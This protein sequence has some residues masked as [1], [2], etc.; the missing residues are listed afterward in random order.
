MK[1][2]LGRMDLGDF[3]AADY[4]ESKRDDVTALP[5]IAIAFSG[6]GY[7]ALMNGAGA[8]KAFDS[9][10]DGATGGGQL[11]GLFQASTYV[12]GLSGGSWLV[13]SMYVNNFTTISTLQT[14]DSS[15]VWEFSSSILKGPAKE[16]LSILNRAS[17]FD[18]LNDSVQSK[19][20]AGYDT[21]ITDYWSRALSYQLINA[22][23]GGPAYTWSSI[24]EDAAFAA[25]EAPM[26]IV[27]ADGRAPGEKLI[28]INTTEFE[29]NPFEFGSFDPTTYAFA[30][31]KYIGSK[32]V[33][34]Q[35]PPNESCVRGF[36]NAAYVMGTSSSLFNQF[37]L[38]SQ[39]YGGSLNQAAQFLIKKVLKLMDAGSEDIADYSPNPFYLFNNETNLS[40]NS[41]RLTLV[42]GGEDLQNIPFAPV[43]LPQR[44]VDVVFAVESSADT[45][46]NWPNGTAMVAT[47]QR[48]QLPENSIANGTA[49]PS[50][51][52][53]NTFV[54]LGF[55]NRPTFFGCNATNTTRPTPLVVY[56]PNAPYIFNSNVSTFDLQHDN[57]VRDAVILNGYNVATQANGTLD[58]SWGT[59]VACAV[60]SRSF[61]R[62]QTPVPDACK[63][64]FDKY[65]W[66]GRLNS[67][68]PAQKYEPP[69]KAAVD[70][71]VVIPPS[72][73]GGD[74]GNDK[75]QKSDGALAAGSNAVIEAG[76]AFAN[77]VTSFWDSLTG[78]DEPPAA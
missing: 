23:D 42:D 9:R 65:C 64:C 40:A 44:A 52:D 72:T 15:S 12:S 53:Q 33:A 38:Q 68:E 20:D 60:L 4:I 43:I 26:P 37:L 25:A 34:G 22:T 31:L 75:P 11:G 7:R 63:T 19:E 18:D 16:G 24:A 14:E 5:N 10:T 17:Y 45:E 30:P 3:N 47:Y 69:F 35:L 56:I 21:T 13:G 49:F 50:I 61:D 59:C 48:S 36:D 55:N 46:F 70:Q 39:S 32:F 41:T 62:T 76:K 58:T 77:T 6:G 27:V 8:L 51:P 78:N 54:N 29:F 28:S 66:D 1:E 74:K 67:T 2:F 73:D 71:Q 57:V